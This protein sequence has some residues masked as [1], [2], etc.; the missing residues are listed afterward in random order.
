MGCKLYYTFYIIDLSATKELLSFSEMLAKSDSK[1]RKRQQ[2]SLKP[3][4]KKKQVTNKVFYGFEC[5]HC[6]E[7]R[8]GDSQVR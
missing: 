6:P 4:K 3:K 7:D 8:D 1:K 5:E 2:E